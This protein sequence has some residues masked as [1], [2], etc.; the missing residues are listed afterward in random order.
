MSFVR[1]TTY[2]PCRWMED[3]LVMSL[4]CKDMSKDMRDLLPQNWKTSAN[5]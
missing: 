5:L 2:Y 1:E 4:K 3:V